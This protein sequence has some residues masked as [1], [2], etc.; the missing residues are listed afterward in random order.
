MTVNAAVATHIGHR[1]KRNEDSYLLGEHL[2]AIADGMGGYVAGDV[3]SNTV[4]NAIRPFDR[5][6]D[7]EQLT[8]ALGQA[9]EAANLAMRQK[10]AAEPAVAGM[11][12]TLVAVMWAGNQFAL[13]NIGDSR[14]YLLRGGTLTQLTDDHVYGRLLAGAAK[15]PTLPERLSRFLDGRVD[16]RSPDL[17][18]IDVRPGD[19]LLLCSD[20]LSSYVEHEAIR[21]VLVTESRDRAVERLIALTLDAGAPDNV[22]VAVLDV[23][24]GN[25]T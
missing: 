14:A 17:S 23:E 19:R 20:G 1:K 8:V 12:T 16:G 21:E 15:V 3:A 22:T 10:S 24:Q 7:P 6:T 4:I 5:A 11:G 2:I 18:P 25:Q 9:V 13:A